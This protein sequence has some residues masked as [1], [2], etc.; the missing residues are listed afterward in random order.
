MTR[1]LDDLL[2]NV[3][4]KVARRPAVDIPTETPACLC[5]NRY[6]FI[7]RIASG[8]RTFDVCPHCN[9][10]NLC[11][12]CNGTGSLVSIN[13]TTGQEELVPNSCECLIWEHRVSRLNA[14]GVPEKY[15]LAEFSFDN[16][17]YGNKHLDQNM[18]DKF[19]ENQAL[20]RNFCEQADSII[21]RGVTPGEKYFLTLVGPVGTGKTYFAICA[22]KDLILNFGHSGKFI[23]FQSLL[24]KI[25][26]SY[27]KKTSEDDIMNPLRLTDVLLIDEF[28]KGRTENEW[29]IEKLDD[30]VNSRYNS[31]RVTIITS[32]YLPPELLKEMPTPSA[33]N[34]KPKT[35]SSQ[36]FLQDDSARNPR[37][38]T[39][40]T[41]TLPERIGERMYDRIV[42]ASLFIDFIG[43]PSF[44]KS[45]ACDFLRRFQKETT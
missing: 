28:G 16:I 38:E 29:E 6:Y 7:K 12:V 3:S 17:R 21:K 5:E 26:D 4:E 30:L 42:E 1:S 20:I 11:R 23:D 14:S 34:F 2:K 36:W 24:N 19:E 27:T 8:S 44:R 13:P 41:T 40:W 15:L 45:Q 32:N 18:A 10:R 25:R 43:I 37:A 39:Y 22:L 31:G 35:H 33:G 9:P